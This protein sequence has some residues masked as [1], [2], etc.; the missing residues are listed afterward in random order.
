MAY[1]IPKMCQT[2]N[3]SYQV[4]CIGQ[5]K[6]LNRPRLVDISTHSLTIG[7]K[8]LPYSQL[9]TGINILTISATC[10]TSAKGI[11]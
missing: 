11:F 6:L 4:L 7:L 3:G 9:S 10:M 1:S 5:S 8:H 2:I